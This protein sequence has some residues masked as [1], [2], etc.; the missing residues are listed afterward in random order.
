VFLSVQE[1]R[2]V[3]LSTT[4]GAEQWIYE[5]GENLNH[6]A[7]G[8]TGIVYALG[9]QRLYSI[10]PD[11]TV[12]WQSDSDG[13]GIAVG[14]KWL[15]L[16]YLT[17]PWNG[18][19]Q[20]INPENGSVVWSYPINAT[21]SVSPVLGSDG[22]VFIA[23]NDGFLYALT[24]GGELLWKYETRGP[25]YT[26]PLVDSE[27]TVYVNSSDGWLY[28]IGFDGQ[29]Q[30]KDRLPASS[31]GDPL[32]FD[33]GALL[34]PGAYYI[35]VFNTH[36][37]GMDTSTWPKFRSN[38]MNTGA[39]KQVCE[40][41][42]E[43]LCS[44]GEN[45]QGVSTCAD[46]GLGWNECVCDPPCVPLT[47]DTAG[48]NCSA[49]P[50]GCGDSID[51]GGCDSTEVCVSGT[52]EPQEQACQ[53]DPCVKW[54]FVIGRHCH[55]AL[56]SPALAADG[57]VYVGAKDSTLYAINADG[58]EK[59]HFLADDWI[60]SS[61][62]IGVDGTVYF[63][64]YDKRLYAVGQD[65]ELKWKFYTYGTI[66]SSPALGQDGTIYV[67]SNDERFYA[68]NPDGT[69]K[70]HFV[71]DGWITSSPAIGDDGTIYFGSTDKK[72]YA[73][74]PDGTKKWEFETDG[75]VESSPAIGHDG[76][77]YVGSWDRNLYAL[78][79]DGTER[80]RFSTDGLI[81][82]SPVIGPDGTVYVGSLDEH[83]YAIKDDGTLNWSY[84]TGRAVETAPAIANDGTVYV[85]DWDGAVH[86]I[87]SN[88]INK[89]TLLLKRGASA[90][91]VI[92]DDGHM[93]IGCDDGNL[94][95]VFEP[96]GGLADS[97]WPKFQKNKANTGG[98]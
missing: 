69:E 28:A 75:I 66:E 33:G 92:G 34:L 64:S 52:C 5:A 13:V 86:A 38:N 58:T 9:H 88:G 74:R 43:R 29:L 61:P 46:D 4:T 21:I 63:G 18:G 30:W 37:K 81:N 20:A 50:D 8:P 79:F 95:A 49:W 15:Y 2:L 87:N 36:G 97:P 68:V 60:R 11:G 54:K 12:K 56:S 1:G 27:Q 80:W 94:Y 65:G 59:W 23:A 7:A 45:H 48:F 89:W 90:S 26:H 39:V 67:G 42:T 78:S 40:P 76:S 57:T 93:Y 70:W 35:S 71:T 72:V 44:H 83:L 16:T 22:T 82:S 6:L 25:N 77:V 51:C 85:A 31:D 3:A 96:N 32:M 91:L 24:T 19:V 41:G 53:D 10:N 55:H 47:C 62:T 17:L 73:L 98:Q 84:N 14:R